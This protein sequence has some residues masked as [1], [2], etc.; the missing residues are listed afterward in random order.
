MTAMISDSFP[1]AMTAR[2]RPAGGEVVHGRAEEQ[3]IVRQLLRHA[4]QGAGGVVL[5]EGEPGIGKSLLLRDSTDKAAEQRFSLAAG[6][7]DRLGQGIPFFALRWALREP[8]A[9]PG[10]DD[11]GR[12]LPDA[13]AWWITRVRAHLEQ[14]AAAAPVLV[15]LDDLHWASPAT[16]ATLRA[17]LRDLKRH[18]VAW[19]LARSGTSQCPADY[20]F[21]LLEK[22]GAARVTLAPL[23]EDAVAAMLTD[24]FGA[25]PDQGLADLAR[26]A[27]GNP[28]LVAELIAG[29]RDDHAVR[30]AGGRAVLVS[31]R[32]PRRVHL[33]AERRLAGLGKQARQLLVTA[34]VLGPAFRLEDAAEML[35]ESPATLLPAVEEAMDAAIVAAAGHAF[36][37]R[38]QLLCRA[39]GETIPPPARKALHRQYA[40]LLLTRGQS[41]T[42]AAGHL[43]RAAHPGDPLSLAGLDKAAAQTLGSAPQTAAAL[44]VRALELTSPADPAAQSRAVAA[45]EALATAG[46]LDRAARIA[47]DML[48]KPLP[49]AVED[50]LRCALASVL[51]AGGQARGAADQ[52]QLVLSRPQLSDEVR[53]HALTAQLQA[54]AGLRDELAGAVAD[55]ILA[56][57]GRHSDHTAAAARLARAVVSWD[58]G[59]IGEGLEL[60]RDAA[61][62]PVAISPDAR[63]AQPLLALAAALIDLRQIKEAEDMLCAT[64]NTAWQKIPAGAALSL[65]QARIHLA[66]GRLADAAAKGQA[67]VTLA[68]GPRRAQLRLS[69]KQRTERDR[70]APWRSHGRGPAHRLPHRREPA[71]R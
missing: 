7:E 37:F 17:L 1:G 69:S 42:R 11:L 65:L 40:E 3:K 10:A 39:V 68:R 27:A 53:D 49:T 28:S 62:H 45:V 2:G 46:R 48:A 18:P 16:L 24:A 58:N 9:G 21:S 23:D 47:G 25:L 52:V 22:D 30:V 57:P 70:A 60:L 54:L 38:H 33:L 64:D 5:V 34:A 15:C 67:G 36:A 41:A 32:L 66:A 8:F 12:D 26:D 31:A 4:Q 6:A 63:H 71:V 59:H 43:L 61:R 50:R 44:A 20:L 29:L 55:T 19:L 35:G 56:A 51:C 13:T 14:R